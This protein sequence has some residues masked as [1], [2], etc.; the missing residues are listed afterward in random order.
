LEPRAYSKALGLKKELDW[1]NFQ[2]GPGLNYS[3]QIGGALPG[4][5]VPSLI[6]LGLEPGWPLFLLNWASFYSHYW[7][8]L[9]KVKNF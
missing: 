1:R 9:G 3:G 6:Y 2:K 5:K 7:F 8:K 4:T